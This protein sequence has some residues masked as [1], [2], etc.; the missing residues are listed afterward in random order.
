MAF[1]LGNISANQDLLI[2]GGGYLL[3]KS[4]GIIDMVKTKIGNGHY[5][6]ES[7]A[8]EQSRQFISEIHDLAEK[9][10][11]RLEK[12]AMEAVVHTE[13]LRSMDS[14]LKSLLDIRR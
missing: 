8:K 3:L 2:A 12:A 9:Q 4:F 5:R 10:S 1:D 11:A 13:L 14:T 7:E 6:S